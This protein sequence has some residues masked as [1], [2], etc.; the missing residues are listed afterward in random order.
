[1]TKIKKIEISDFRIYQGKQDFNFERDNDVANLIALYAPNGYGKTSFFDAIEWGFSNKIKRFE[2]NYIRKAIKDEQENTILLTNTDSYKVG[3]KGK[4]NI[5]TNK[6]SF[7]EKTV[8]KYKKPNTDFYNDY[9]KGITTKGA[10]EIDLSDI[11]ETNILTQDQID[12]FLRFKTPEEKF[13]ALKDFWPESEDATNRL[14]QLS[15]LYKV[16]TNDINIT[17]GE[18]KTQEG[19]IMGLNTDS[20]DIL[21]INLWL[22]KVKD[23]EIYECNISIEKIDD[24]ITQEKYDIIHQE[25]LRNIKGLALERDKEELIKGELNSL[26]DKLTNYTIDNEKVETLS[27]RLIQLQKRKSNFLNL[28]KSKEIEK[29][30]SD[31]ISTINENIEKYNYVNLHILDYKSDIKKIEDFKNE[32][33]LSIT[34]NT[35]I[36]DHIETIKKSISNF[37]QS[38]KQFIQNLLDNEKQQSNIDEQYD[39]FV[40]VD[41]NLKEQKEEL[42]ELNI[43]IKEEDLKIKK[44]QERNL[45]FDKTIE[46]ED[47]S[48]I[49]IA[50]NLDFKAYCFDLDK[51][52]RSINLMNSK[53]TIKQKELEKSGTLNDDLNKIILFGEDYITKTNSSD[54][55][56]CKTTFETF[57]DLLQKVKSEKKN[58]LKITEQ[59]N[60][61]S[62]LS[63]KLNNLI[64]SKA[65]LIDK[66]NNVISL[67]KREISKR[68][69]KTQD[70]KNKLV[71]KVNDIH[72][73][74]RVLELELKKCKEFFNN[75]FNETIEIN[76]E[77]IKSLKEKLQKELL[78][79]STKENRIKNIIE[80]KGDVLQKKETRLLVNQ[81]KIK[82]NKNTIESIQSSEIFRKTKNIINEI[83][84]NNSQLDKTLIENGI[85]ANEKKL[86]NKYLAFSSL[87]KELHSI[88]KNI[89]DDKIQI[90][91]INLEGEIFN[92]ESLIT[93]GKK[94]IEEYLIKWNKNI[95][96]KEITEDSIKIYQLKN[97]KK[98]DD[99]L[100]IEKDLNN[101]SIDLE[102]IKDNIKRNELE[103]KIEK[104]KNILPRLHNSF[105][106]IDAAK[107]DCMSFV[108]TGINNYFNK[109]VINEI[110]S[111]IEP[112]PKLTKIDF[113]T[114][115]NEKGE[116]RLLITTGNDN[117]EEKVN[118]ILFL[119]AGQVNVLS[120]SIFLAKAFEYGNETIETIFMDDPIQN[121]SDINVLSFI[122]LLRTLIS[123][124]DKQIVISTHDEK[125]F[126]LLQNKLPEEYCNTKYFEFESE[127]K[128]K[129]L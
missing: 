74:I 75:V 93:R 56:L 79:I 64:K 94:N 18:L 66:I 1:M 10:I 112:H 77:T 106:K 17:E 41:K 88:E 121:L 119:S 72:N 50:S 87:L 36:L 22:Q 14:K 96:S 102:L 80:E 27:K 95:V 90:D 71:N 33:Q 73:T 60:E 68:I 98:I 47:Y 100:L 24:T 5:I 107:N 43:K 86:S 55:P 57:E 38:E 3:L 61:I 11:P 25:N 7:L 67:E 52:T 51:N 84:L 103:E 115:F 12:A 123:K 59:K 8:S 124:H 32:N 114:D 42:P 97:Q 125:F 15:D 116:P 70:D 111:R 26:K 82:K 126:R 28:K 49:T 129:K 104:L 53:I 101:L 85:D 35:K 39:E 109:E 81:S 108:E 99:L 44:L 128:L 54:C 110:Y 113:S 30:I 23:Q 16:V 46:N 76:E 83:G 69:A 78:N 45:E 122:D 6:D 4:V 31:E 117:I 21:Q 62:I 63:N 118:P 127:G 91:E 34:E 105:K 92:T 9:R 65:S 48:N 2:N 40:R 20:K 58:T 89:S 29:S 37:K 120:L 19:L 13:A